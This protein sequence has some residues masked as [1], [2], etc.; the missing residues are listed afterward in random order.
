MASAKVEKERDALIAR[1]KQSRDV[2]LKALKGVTDAAATASPGGNAWS[3][4][5]VAEHVLIAE[6]QMLN[7]WIKY[8]VPGSSDPAKDEAIARGIV[9]RNRKDM[10]PESSLPKGKVI[11]MA[12]AFEQFDFY[13]GQTIGYVEATEEDFRVKVVKHPL[14]GELDGYQLFLLMAGHTERHAAQIEE[15]K[16]G[17]S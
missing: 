11:N 6:R 3:I 5:Q 8:A 16:K 13:R 14:A 7:L 1:L 10:A 12:Q 15:V 4:L 17:R 9:D 2:Y